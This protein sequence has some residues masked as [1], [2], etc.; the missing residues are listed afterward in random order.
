MNGGEH[1]AKDAGE[2][3]YRNSQSTEQDGDLGGVLQSGGNFKNVREEHSQGNAYNSDTGR[4]ENTEPESSVDGAAC[5]R[6]VSFGIG[7]GDEADDRAAETQIKKAEVGHGRDR[8][9]PDSIGIHT[10]ASHHE[11]G[12]EKRN[13]HAN[14]NGEPV[15]QYVESETL[16]TSHSISGRKLTGQDDSNSARSCFVLCFAK[17]NPFDACGLSP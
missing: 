14:G 16:F 2:Q 4:D 10:K 8:E 5:L 6:H 7:F 13:H 9:D 1:T 11:W 3:C 17:H 15:H 12:K